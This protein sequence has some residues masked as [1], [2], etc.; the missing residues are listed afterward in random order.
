MIKHL[1]V[2]TSMVWLCA[3]CASSPSLPTGVADKGRCD[4]LAEQYHFYERSV[5]DRKGQKAG[6]FD[7]QIGLQQ[8][9]RGQY[10]DGVVRLEKAVRSF[11]V[12]PVS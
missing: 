10:V 4:R 5:D 6:A 7:Y 2:I 1:S 3:A 9:D 12:M 11:G 8:C